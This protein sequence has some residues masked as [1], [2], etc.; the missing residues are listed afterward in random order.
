MPAD[1]GVE[2][3]RIRTHLRLIEEQLKEDAV[4][5]VLLARHWQRARAMK[6][7]MLT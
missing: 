3:S 5:S 7:P 6:Q 2:T 1:A 4:F